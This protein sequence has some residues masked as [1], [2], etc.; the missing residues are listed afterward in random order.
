[1][2][3]LEWILFQLNGVLTGSLT[4]EQKLAKLTE[5]VANCSEEIGL[6]V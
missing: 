1:M 3:D 5:L 6:S 4:T 2:T